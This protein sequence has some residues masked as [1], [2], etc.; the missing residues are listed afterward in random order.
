MKIIITYVSAGGGH[1]RAAEAVYSYIKQHCPSAQPQLMDALEKTNTLFRLAYIFSYTFMVRHALFLWKCVFRVTDFR[2]LRPSTRKAASFLN[3][4]NSVNFC[5]FLV[6]ENPDFIISTHFLPSEIAAF[7]K[8]R[9]KI[10]S[11]LFTVVTDFSVHPFWVS[12]G[13]D[14]YIVASDSTKEELLLEGIQESR[15]KVSGIP[16]DVKF[17]QSYDRYTL[18]RKFGIDNSKFTVLIMTG[19]FGVGPLEEITRSL[20]A[21]TQVLVVCASNKILYG[22]LKLAGL[23]NVRVFGFVDNAQELMAVSDIIITKPG[24]LSISEALSMELVPVFISWIPGQEEKNMEILK[25]Y[26]IGIVPKNAGEIRDIVLDLKGHP[27]RLSAMKDNI[28]KVR[29]PDAIREICNAVCQGGAG[30]AC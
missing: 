18:C 27:E 1:F 19:S 11:K 29:R 23:P 3:R 26:G 25:K 20:C 24:G 2:P 16:I 13:T 22:K 6:R 28:R 4:I 12:A 5:R 17:L 30:L 15:V 10:K 9:S 8:A 14:L 7:L 21:D